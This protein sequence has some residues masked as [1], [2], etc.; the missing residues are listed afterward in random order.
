MSLCVC[1]Q[2]VVNR[3]DERRIESSVFS[4][5]EAVNGVC[6]EGDR[7]RFQTLERANG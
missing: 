2:E 1:G 5:E 4:G 7:E 6:G 3:R